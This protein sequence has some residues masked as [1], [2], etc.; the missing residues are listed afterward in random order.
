M[1]KKDKTVL[2]QIVFSD[3]F[4]IYFD[5]VIILIRLGNLNILDNQGC[6]RVFCMPIFLYANFLACCI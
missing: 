1:M 2:I 6:N 5:L 4:S 3:G